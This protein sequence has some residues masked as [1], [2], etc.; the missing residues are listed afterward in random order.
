LAT[1]GS[2]R[3]SIEACVKSLKYRL[4]AM[5]EVVRAVA[6][7]AMFPVVIAPVRGLAPRLIVNGLRYLK[8][9]ELDHLAVAQFRGA[10]SA[11]HQMSVSLTTNKNTPK[12]LHHHHH[13][14]TGAGSSTS[15]H[16][17]SNAFTTAQQ[18]MAHSDLRR[19]VKNGSAMKFDAFWSGCLSLLVQGEDDE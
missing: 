7:P 17:G 12:E 1:H 4:L 11:L 18:F 9:P 6:L 13:H 3:H 10:M 14:H 19:V 15:D 2:D 8:S 5:E 16:V